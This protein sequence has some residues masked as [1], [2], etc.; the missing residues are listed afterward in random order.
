MGKDRYDWTVGVRISDDT[1]HTA[2]RL[3][4]GTCLLATGADQILER[5]VLVRHQERYHKSTDPEERTNLA[6][7]ARRSGKYGWTLGREISLPT[8]YGCSETQTPTGV[9][10]SLKHSHLRRGHFHRVR[11]A[12]G[13]E[14][15]D[16]RSWPSHK[17]L[18]R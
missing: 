17:S 11:P 15:R 10:G 12:G 2:V 8:L 13:A 16:I 1:M 6:E 3:A 14:I 7:K 18:R 9:H 5:D 4:V